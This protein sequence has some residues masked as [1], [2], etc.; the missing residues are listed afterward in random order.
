MLGVWRRAN[1]TDRL[2]LGYF[3]GLGVLILLLRHRVPGWPAF[4]QLH[5][6]FIALVSALVVGARRFPTAHAWYPLVMPVVTFT[7]VAQLNFLLVDRWRDPYLLA[8]ESRIFPEPPTVWLSRFASPLVTEILEFG[9][10]SYFFILIGVAGV[11]YRRVD[12]APFFGV[13]AATVLGY[14]LCYVVFVTFP[15][16]G[17]A[18]TLRHLHTVP[19]PGGPIHGL[20]MFVQRAG[21]HGNAFPSA[22]VAG[23]VVPLI[24]AFRYL[25]RLAVWLTPVFVLLCIGAVYDRY[26]YA[27]DVIAGIPVG[28]AAAYFVM[29]A[30]ARP[31]W[32]RR[33]NIALAS[34]INA[35]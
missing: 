12:K 17:P 30:Q 1:F 13:M 7:E 28:A 8:F 25:P 26:H 34:P 19:L 10:F 14:M 29:F 11:L 4:L 24:F 33:L 16:E 27:S 21:V 20:V 15:T 31:R 32:A 22:H 3:V 18:H 35:P 2:Y 5:L 6:V 23:A 9:Y